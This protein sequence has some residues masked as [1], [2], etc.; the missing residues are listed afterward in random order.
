M[1]EED[2]IDISAPYTISTD[3]GKKRSCNLSNCSTLA[4]FGLFKFP[5]NKELFEEWKEACKL[6]KAKVGQTRVCSRHFDA[7]DISYRENG[8]MMLKKGSVP[9]L[10]LP[11]Q[12]KEVEKEGKISVV[13][14]SQATMEFAV[15]P[16]KCLKS[17]EKQEKKN[18]VEEVQKE[19]TAIG[20]DHSYQL[21]EADLLRQQVEK[22]KCDKLHLEKRNKIL[23]QKLSAAKKFHVTKKFSNAL[24]KTTLLKHFTEAQ[25]DNFLNW[26][27]RNKKWSDDDIALGLAMRGVSKK[28]Y[29]FLRNNR[30]FPLP[31][32]SSVQ[33]HFDKFH[34]TPGSGL[35]DNSVEML[36]LMLEHC[37][38][39]EKLAILM[40]GTCQ[41]LP[42]SQYESKND[43]IVG[44]HNSCQLVLLCGLANNWRIPIKF[45]FDTALTSSDIMDTLT[46]LQKHDI[47]IVGLVCSPE[48]ENNLNVSKE[49]GVGD[50][51]PYFGHPVTDQPVYWIWDQAQ[52][53]KLVKKQLLLHVS[54]NQAG[55]SGGSSKKGEKTKETNCCPLGNLID[56]T[57]TVICSA[58]KL[59]CENSKS[60]FEKQKSLIFSLIEGIKDSNNSTL[61]QPW[62]SALNVSLQ[63]SIALESLT[64]TK[65]VV[66]AHLHSGLLTSIFSHIRYMESSQS[67]KPSALEFMQRLRLCILGSGEGLAVVGGLQQQNGTSDRAVKIPVAAS[68]ATT[69]ATRI[70]E[71]WKN[72][73]END[74]IIVT[75]TNEEN[76]CS[77]KE[78]TTVEVTME[79]IESEGATTVMHAKESD[80]ELVQFLRG[81]VNNEESAVAKCE[82]VLATE[83]GLAVVAGWIAHRWHKLDPSLVDPDRPGKMEISKQAKSNNLMWMDIVNLDKLTFPSSEWMRDVKTME[84]SFK[85]YHPMEGIAHG[86]NVIGNFVQHL[87][88]QVPHRHKKVLLQFSRARTSMRLRAINKS[89]K[90][91]KASKTVKKGGK[92]KVVKDGKKKTNAHG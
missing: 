3:G 26:K 85:L 47:T 51:Q 45:D 14:N 88:S 61:L 52:L 77:E 15:S 25:L 36:K 59:C 79:V 2:V 82:K 75:T 67:R 6:S 24:V 8:T 89:V 29:S 9:T 53:V 33:A 5:V 13:L 32:L 34:V 11:S 19:D 30:I 63:S 65:T 23:K 16:L 39:E 58:S 70:N 81:L 83:D 37:K 4:S 60:V 90:R 40:V 28:A 91:L 68:V 18:V 72:V 73:E 17:N 35:I 55:D 21:T 62:Q 41:L 12:E 44:P 1:E 43:S 66:L 74:I 49:M 27:G 57:S 86:P 38:S 42:L 48:T 84:R 87:T 7:Q 76:L 64:L 20:L 92:K 69:V 50:S 78:A 80:A 22:L 46:N 56:Q 31:P 54:Q 71:R 10:H